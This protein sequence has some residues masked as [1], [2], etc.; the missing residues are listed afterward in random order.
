MPWISWVFRTGQACEPSKG[1]AHP[2]GMAAELLPGLEDLDAYGGGPYQA[3]NP[4]LQILKYIKM[5]S[6][7]F[8]KPFPI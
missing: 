3:N 5:R 4:K 7:G 1:T 2:D 8:K 6:Y